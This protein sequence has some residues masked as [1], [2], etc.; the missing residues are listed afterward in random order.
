MIISTKLS[1]E[2]QI[3]ET[4]RIEKGLNYTTPIYKQIADTA[5][6]HIRNMQN[7]DDKTV[8]TE[9]GIYYNAI[10]GLIRSGVLCSRVTGTDGMPEIRVVVGSQ[11]YQCRESI[12]RMILG[13]EA[14]YLISPYEDTFES[15]IDLVFPKI[16]PT[17]SEE[18][19]AVVQDGKAKKGDI[20]ALNA[21]H[22]AEIKK[23]KQQYEDEISKLKQSQGSAAVVSPGQT[24]SEVIR[25]TVQDPEQAKQL[26]GLKNENIRLQGENDKLRADEKQHEDELKQVKQQLKLKTA[27]LDEKNKYVYDPNYDHY[28]SDELPNIINALEFTHKDL[29]AKFIAL[30]GCAAGLVISALLLL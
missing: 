15:Y 7:E 20:K 2:E 9:Y 5:L 30:A 4:A 25:E 11:I 8:V 1:Q 21:Q 18:P 13:D 16:Q 17:E 6:Q 10:A 22:K 23:L 26:T 3:V 19:E 28:Y 29:A 12:L 14:D 27:E 24:Q